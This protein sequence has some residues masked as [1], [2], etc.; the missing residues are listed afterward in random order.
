MKLIPFLFLFISSWCFTQQRIG[1]DINYRQAGL[2][3]SVNYHKVIANNWLISGA[4]DYGRKGRYLIDYRDFNPSNTK[5]LSPWSEVNQAIIEENST[6]D[7]K[8]YFVK[9]KAVTAQIGLGYFHNFDIKHGVRGHV[10]VQ[11]GQAFNTVTG[12]YAAADQEYDIMKRTTTSHPVAAVSAEVYHT[13]QIWQKFT[14]YY[15]L[16]TPYYLKVD[17]SRFNPV[18]KEDN[19]FGLEPEIS[20]GIT[21]LIGD[22]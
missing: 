12:T 19:F 15:G 2:N 18:R 6:F 11:Y 21:Y 3:V 9:N 16:K 4:V 1:L 8:R 17:K 20:I 7:V 5:V 13:I 14:L 10:F 22:C